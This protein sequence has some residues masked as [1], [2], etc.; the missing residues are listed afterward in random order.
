MFFVLVKSYW[1]D[2]SVSGVE[3]LQTPVGPERI[4]RRANASRAFRPHLATGHR[5]VQQVSVGNSNDVSRASG[6]KREWR[7]SP[8]RRTENESLSFT[9]GGHV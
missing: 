5:A 4:R 3:G 7:P 1:S 8:T 6:K 9:S 2:V